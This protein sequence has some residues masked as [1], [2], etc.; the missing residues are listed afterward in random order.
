VI[1]FDETIIKFDKI[2]KFWW[3]NTF[4]KYYKIYNNYDLADS[5]TYNK[6]I[7]INR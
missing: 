5:S 3:K 6:W 7:Q 4:E 2:N 1:D